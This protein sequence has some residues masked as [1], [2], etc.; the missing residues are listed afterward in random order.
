MLPCDS[1]EGSIRIC[2]WE[3]VHGLHLNLCTHSLV[4]WFKSNILCVCTSCVNRRVDSGKNHGINGGVSGGVTGRVN[5][6]VNRG[7]KG[8][9]SSGLHPHHSSGGAG[10][11]SQPLVPRKGWGGGLPMA[12][13][14]GPQSLPGR[15]S[16]HRAEGEH[17][18]CCRAWPQPSLK[19][20]DTRE[21]NEHVSRQAVHTIADPVPIN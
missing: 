4:C 1:R 15:C 2:S 11:A 16:H 10:R 21:G 6:G 19:R 18:M 14:S 7:V 9:V 8:R 5:G 13:L 17:T 3:K 20:P 12:V